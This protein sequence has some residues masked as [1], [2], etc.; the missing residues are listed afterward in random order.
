MNEQEILELEKWIHV[1]LFDG[2]KFVGLMKQGLW[3]RPNAA[4]YTNNIDEAGRYT[5]DE[6]E[7]RKYPHSDRP[8]PND[9]RVT[10]HEFPVTQY[11]RD[12]AWSFRVLKKCAE[13]LESIGNNVEFSLYEKGKWKAGAFD[14]DMDFHCTESETAGLTV[15]QFAKKLFNTESK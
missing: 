2:D 1:N 4:G 7:K 10:I 8:C 11:A 15:C 5:R 9:E 6:A 12:D 13:R 14:V 3:Y